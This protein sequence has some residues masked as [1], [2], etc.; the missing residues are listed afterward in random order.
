MYV[1]ASPTAALAATPHALPLALRVPTSMLMK[2]NSARMDHDGGSTA[3]APR[4]GSEFSTKKQYLA[5]SGA[6]SRMDSRPG[7]ACGTLT[8]FQTGVVRGRGVA[9]SFP[10]VCPSGSGPYTNLEV[11]ASGMR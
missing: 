11:R 10:R 9:A 1:S 8:Q 5:P 4:Q 2:V 6:G 3:R 7:H